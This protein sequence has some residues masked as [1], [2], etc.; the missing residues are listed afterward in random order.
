MSFTAVAVSIKYEFKPVT[1][2]MVSR[3]SECDFLARETKEI[4]H[5]NFVEQRYFL[6]LTGELLAI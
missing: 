2:R 4:R 5:K 6:L 3:F 1:N